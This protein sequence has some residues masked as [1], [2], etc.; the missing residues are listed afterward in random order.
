MPITACRGSRFQLVVF[1]GGLMLMMSSLAA[2]NGPVATS[3]LSAQGSGH[4]RDAGVPAGSCLQERIQH[5]AQGAIL[6]PVSCDRPGAVK[7]LDSVVFA[8]DADPL[9]VSGLAGFDGRCSSVHPGAAVLVPSWLGTDGQRLIAACGESANDEGAPSG[10][11]PE[12]PALAERTAKD[13]GSVCGWLPPSMVTRLTEVALSQCTDVSTGATKLVSYTKDPSE[14]VGLSVC[15][16]ITA[17]RITFSQ[18][19]AQGIA[20]GDSV[21]HVP[22]LGDDAT[23]MTSPNGHPDVEVLVGRY[24]LGFNE[25]AALGIHHDGLLKLARG[26]LG[27]LPSGG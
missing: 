21:K 25:E 26:V 7:V 6:L 13:V 2:C 24:A 10:V 16:Q 27:E 1:V 9:A 8:A 22:G 3:G 23:L 15:V 4:K 11:L 19:V 14:V 18:R 20:A 12:P 17:A 5:G